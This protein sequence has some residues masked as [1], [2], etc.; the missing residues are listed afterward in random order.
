MAITTRKVVINEANRDFTPAPKVKIELYRL[1]GD[2]RGIDPAITA[3]YDT[4]KTARGW[5][6]YGRWLQREALN[7]DAIVGTLRVKSDAVEDE[8]LAAAAGEFFYAY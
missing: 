7:F 8:C 6:D 4:T 3:T 5:G 1:D 2:L